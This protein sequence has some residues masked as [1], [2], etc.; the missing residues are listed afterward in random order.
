MLEFLIANLPI[1]LCALAGMALIVL[2][3]FLPGFGVPGISGLVLSLAAVLITR[4]RYG[5]VAALGF[6]VVMIALMGIVI[7]ISLKSAAK[8]A[9]Y[10]TNL[11]LHA[12][13]SSEEGYDAATDMQVFLGKQGTVSTPLRPVGIA[14]FDG[15]R[16][17]VVTE[18]EYVDADESVTIVRVE[19]SRIVVRR[20]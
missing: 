12:T 6:T 7:S 11:V 4:M 1:V 9:L 19:G 10:K 20:A 13:E 5:W 16:L 3:V 2:E 18:G 14:E 17:N 15:V 8:G